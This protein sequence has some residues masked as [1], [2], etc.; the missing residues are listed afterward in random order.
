MYIDIEDWAIKDKKLLIAKIDEPY[1]G[2][3]K[4]KKRGV[5]VK[6]A[7]FTT[8]KDRDFVWRKVKKSFDCYTTVI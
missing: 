8:K 6:F 1:I 3:V 4:M 7:E 2:I 5:Y